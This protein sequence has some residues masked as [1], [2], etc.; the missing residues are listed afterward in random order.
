MQET[1]LQYPMLCV[2]KF[3]L[4]SAQGFELIVSAKGDLTGKRLLLSPLERVRLTIM[5]E[6]GVLVGTML[7]WLNESFDGRI[8]K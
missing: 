2:M 8:P 6:A 5:L 3:N 1:S 7:K 4:G